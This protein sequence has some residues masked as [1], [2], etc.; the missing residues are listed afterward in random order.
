MCLLPLFATLRRRP[1]DS[2]RSQG[3]ASEKLG[4]EGGFR[5]VSDFRVAEFGFRVYKF[6]RFRVWALSA[7]GMHY[8]CPTRAQ[9]HVCVSWMCDEALKFPEASRPKAS[10]NDARPFSALLLSQP[11][12]ILHEDLH[13]LHRHTLILYTNPA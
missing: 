1:S 12:V 13:D 3:R 6:I 4:V 5:G 10:P 11:E 9:A 7:L 8:G 2:C